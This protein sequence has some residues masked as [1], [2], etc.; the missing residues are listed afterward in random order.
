MGPNE[1]V[2]LL[3]EEL[4]HVER[5]VAETD[6]LTFAFGIAIGVVIGKK[7]GARGPGKSNREA[8]R[9]GDVGSEDPVWPGRRPDT[10][11]PTNR[12]KPCDAAMQHPH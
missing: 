12:R 7:A 9:L 8:L 1:R 2:D 4:G 5:D 11:P 3:G 10:L 6:M